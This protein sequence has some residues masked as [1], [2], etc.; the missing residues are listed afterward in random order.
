MREVLPQNKKV[1]VYRAISFSKINYGIELYGRKKT[2]CI[3][4]L[5]TTQNRI[6]KILLKKN[7]LTDTNGLHRENNLLKVL[8]HAKLRLLLIS[9]NVLYSKNKI[10]PAYEK[11]KLNAT[12]GR[13]LRNNN[14][15]TITANSYDSSNMVIE[16]AAIYWNNL[17]R[18]EKALQNRNIFKEK[19]SAKLLLQI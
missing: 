5:Q 15:F 16:S 12:Q 9:H 7:I 19:I 8:D 4:K 14:D 11:M 6:L 17:Q 10:N 2:N 13:T 3:K 1:L 18:E